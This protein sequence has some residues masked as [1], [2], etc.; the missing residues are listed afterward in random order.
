MNVVEMIIIFL[1][2]L[3]LIFLYLR[4]NKNRNSSKNLP[5]GPYPW[6]IIG[7]IFQIGRK[8]PHIRLAEISQLYG[9]LISLRIGQRILIVGSSSI[10]ASE[11]LKTHD[12]VL[13]GRDVSRLL[14]NKKPTVHNMN[15]VFTS[16]CDD[17]WRYLRN[18][19]K[20]ELL[21]RKVWILE[22]I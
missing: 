10:A 5:P 19:Y 4:M 15:L 7:N 8:N 13:S 18:I 6:P 2:F 9:P 22:R 14:Q 12:D 16:E 1:V 11:I 3:P 17:G 20:T 21:S